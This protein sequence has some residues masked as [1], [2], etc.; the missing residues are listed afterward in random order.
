[1][2]DKPA[3]E[4]RLVVQEQVEE[5]LRQA[6]AKIAHA[7]FALLGTHVYPD[8]TFT[9]RLA[10]GVVAGYDEMGRP[11]PWTTLGGASTMPPSM[12]TRTPSPCPPAGWTAGSSST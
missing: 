5:P 8:A 9:L 10:F 2:V 12:A 4:L 6:Y 3:R 1:M 7:R 11:A